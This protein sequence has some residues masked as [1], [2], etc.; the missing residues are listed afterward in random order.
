M[1][2]IYSAQSVDISHVSRKYLLTFYTHLNPPIFQIYDIMKHGSSLYVVLENLLE[3][4]KVLIEN[5]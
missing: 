3:M 5:N 4:H 2:I 1:L